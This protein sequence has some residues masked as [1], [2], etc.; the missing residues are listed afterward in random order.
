MTTVIPLII[1][2]ES[3]FLPHLWTMIVTDEVR[4]PGRKGL[5]YE[6]LLV[7]YDGSTQELVDGLCEQPVS[8][9]LPFNDQIMGIPRFSS[10]LDKWGVSVSLGCQT[11]ECSLHEREPQGR[12]GVVIDGPSLVH[13]IYNKV[14]EERLAKADILDSVLLCQK[15]GID[16]V[17]FLDYL[18]SIHIPM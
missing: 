6:Q 14:L 8:S 15:V 12:V 10:Y 4:L 17:R 2:T 18:E 11:L 13:Y 3:T 5:Q 9:S 16:V 7:A 1:P